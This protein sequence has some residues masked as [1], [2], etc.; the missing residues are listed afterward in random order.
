MGLFNFSQEE[1]LSFFAVLVRYS[2]LVS[3]LPFVGD[4]FVPG[5]VKVLLALAM[6]LVLF[7]MLVARGQ[8]HPT[9]ALTWGAS[10]G[11]IAGVIATEVMVGLVLGYVSRFIF[12]TINF[13]GNLVGTFMGF[14]S[15]STFDPHQETQTQI[16][17]EL[18][19]A[20][21][22]LIFLAVDGHHLMLRASLDSYKILGLGGMGGAATNGV[23]V[24]GGFNAA[25][26]EKIVEIS[27]HVI[28]FGIQ[29]AAPVA[30]SLFA[31]NV[32]FGVMAK[33]MPQLNILVLSFAV[34][35]LVG[36]LVLFLSV[37]EYTGA[38]ASVFERTGV[39]LE[40]VMM[41]MAKGR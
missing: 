30:I 10:T 2:V 33:T 22:M 17:A 20:I 40:S 19:M 7:P 18:Q 35:A 24:N 12:D 3:V 38:V 39:W 9:L 26:G 8:I 4:R 14:A 5:P 27:G 15:A 36:L 6:T 31:V 29:L 1:M 37:G 11:G 25:F 32:A 16:V 28:K 23:L 13:G 21:A 41:A 34:S